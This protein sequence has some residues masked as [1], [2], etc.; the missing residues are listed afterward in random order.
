MNSFYVR[1]VVV[2]VLC[3]AA[4]YLERYIENIGYT[5]AKALY[6]TALAKQKLDAEKTLS[7]AN[8]RVLEAEQA[9]AL[10]K[11][12]REKTDATN[13]QTV[14]A[15]S[16]RLAQLASSNRLRDPHATAGCGCGGDT[17]P[18]A[19]A[20]AAGPGHADPAQTAGVL[21]A[22]LTGLLQ[23]LT[24]EADEINIAYASCRADAIDM[25]KKL[26]E[27]QIERRPP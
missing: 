22:E 4:F 21:S 5:R 23:Q 20:T 10:L 11:T 3:A 25:R 1:A 13:K 12:Q 17:A 2:L 7:A 16:D 18:A 24:R 14:V 26:D 6:E 8:A 19:T 15:L 27:L 9:L